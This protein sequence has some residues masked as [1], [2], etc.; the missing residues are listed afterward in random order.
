MAQSEEASGGREN[1]ANLENAMEAVIGAIFLDQ[2]MEI[3]K[4]FILANWTNLIDEMVEPP[5]DAKSSLQEWAQGKGLPLPEYIV[6]GTTGLM[7][8]PIFEV[9]VKLPGF[10]VVTGNGLSKRAAE[11]EAAAKLMS[12]LSI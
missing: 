9:S 8:A 11:Q 2:G 6:V 5:K 3:A 12:L 7:H 1:K 10:E 4:T